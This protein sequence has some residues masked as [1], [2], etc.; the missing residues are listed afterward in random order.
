MNREDIQQNPRAVIEQIFRDSMRSADNSMNLEVDEPSWESFLLGYAAGEDPLFIDFKRAVGEEHLTPAEIF[1]L[2]YPDNPASPEEL[3]V[4]GWVLP[5]REATKK[6]NRE[7]KSFPAERWCR[8]RKWGEIFNHGLRNNIPKILGDLGVDAVAPMASPHWK[9]FDNQGTFIFY[10]NWSER[11]ACYAAGLGTFGLCDGLIT[12]AGKA[13]RCGS[14]VARIRIEATPRPYTRH[15]E[16]CSFFVDGSCGACIS[17]C[18][19]GAI[20]EKGHDK[21]ICCEYVSNVTRAHSRE[22]FGIDIEGCGLCQTG[23]P[24]EGKIPKT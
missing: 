19:V 16:Y 5:Q 7:Q 9:R 14:L 17:R 12:A 3:T 8:S 4:L 1:N 18:P 2:T 22:F 13:H 23:V 10:S 11:H 20:T 15:R 24:C 6:D 21:T